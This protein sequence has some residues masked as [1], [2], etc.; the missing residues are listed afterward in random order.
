MYRLTSIA[1]LAL[2]T[3]AGSVAA[4]PPGA[5]NRDAMK[6]LDFLAGKWKGDAVLSRG[7]EQTKLTQTEDVAFRLDGVVMIVEG[8]GR[9][10]VPGKDE[11]GIVFHALAVMSYDA[12]GKK[13]KVKAYRAE[14]QSVDADLVLGE[15]GFVWGFKEPARGTEVR[16]TMRLTD[17]GEWH[18]VGEYTLDGKSWTKFIE[19]TLTRV[20]E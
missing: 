9:G 12:Q 16:Y 3:G 13:Y 18:E 7:K 8:V 19:M 11:D 15:K 20:K 5:A 4:Q 14:G 6:K 2:L 10:K 17:K 1:V